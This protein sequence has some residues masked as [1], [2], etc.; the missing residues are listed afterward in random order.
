MYEFLTTYRDAIIVR[1]CEKLTARPWPTATATELENGIPLFLTQLAETLRLERTDATGAPTTMGAAA[2][3]HGGDLLRLGFTLSQVVHDY[4]DLCQAVPELA[5]EQNAPITTDEFHT[6][7]RCLDTATADA[8][9][10]HARMTAVARDAE[11]GE[12]AGSV[13][14]ET[15]TV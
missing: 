8:V 7:N 9:T 10:E 12:R 1:A 11:E 3:R 2:T 13:A 15:R 6:L 4:G 14:H 5:M